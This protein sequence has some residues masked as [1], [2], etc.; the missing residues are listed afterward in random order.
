LLRVR[1]GGV[2]VEQVA[3]VDPADLRQGW[4]VPD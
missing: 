2:P 4:R 3:P 1:E